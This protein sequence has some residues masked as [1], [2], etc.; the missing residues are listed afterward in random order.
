[1]EPN[2]LNE[3]GWL[4]RMG[5]IWAAPDD[6]TCKS[7]IDGSTYDYYLMEATLA[8][9]MGKPTT[10]NNTTIATHKPVQI[11][12]MRKRMELWIREQVAPT[13]IPEIQ[14]GC[15]RRPPESWKKAFRNTA[16]AKDAEGVASALGDVMES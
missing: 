4:H 9:H 6:I 5:G 2:T 3:D 7:S 10:I 8:H 14:P 16:K 13:A 12:I 11:E 1:M 15:A